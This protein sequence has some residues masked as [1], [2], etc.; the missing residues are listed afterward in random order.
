MNKKVLL[1]FAAVFGVLGAYLPA[2]FGDSDPLSGWSILGG[3]IGGLFGIWL[4]VVISK[5]WG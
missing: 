4:G 3:M 2:A 5:R 1:F